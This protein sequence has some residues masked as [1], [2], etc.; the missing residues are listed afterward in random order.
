MRSLRGPIAL[1]LVLVATATRLQ[2]QAQLNGRYV[3]DARASDSLP[4]VIDRAVE[5]VGVLMRPMARQYLSRSL[6]APEW[7]RIT[8]E[9]PNVS[10]ATNRTVTPINGPVNGA[11]VHIDRGS[12]VLE[13]STTWANG[14]L[15]R[16]ISSEG[17]LRVN[18]YS[19]SPNGNTLT[20]TARMTSPQMDQPLTYRLVFQRAP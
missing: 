6:V 12:E 4:A 11:P 7:L 13:V 10:I 16:T 9:A 17:M 5:G 14:R 15:E 19:L 18:T 3:Y 20:M 8:Y 1:S 2:A